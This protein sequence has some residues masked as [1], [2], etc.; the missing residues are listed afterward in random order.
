MIIYIKILI[1]LLKFCKNYYHIDLKNT[2]K[3]Q[4]K[5]NNK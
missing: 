3:Y 2:Y 4:K 1:T 5:F